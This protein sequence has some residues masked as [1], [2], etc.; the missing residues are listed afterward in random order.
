MSLQIQLIIDC[1]QGRFEGI[2]MTDTVFEHADDAVQ[3]MNELLDLFATTRYDM[4][5]APIRI[6]EY[7]GWV[8]TFHTDMHSEMSIAAKIVWKPETQI[9]QT[10]IEQ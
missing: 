1:P 4:S 7:G 2:Y 9:L 6:K 3:E 10:K 8:R 5:P